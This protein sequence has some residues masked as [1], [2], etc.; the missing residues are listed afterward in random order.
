MKNRNL[1]T[2]WGVGT[3]IGLLLLG[4]IGVYVYATGDNLY[5]GIK[6]LDRVAFEVSRNYVEEVNPKD[7]VYAG[8]KGML[9][10]LDPH[11]QFF[12]QK[13]YKELM[14]GT[15]G[16][17]SGVGMVIGGREGVLTV[18][19]PIE[20]G[21]AY[22]AGIQAGDK[23]IKIEGE[24]TEGIT[25]EEAST[26]LRG[27]KGT[28]VSLSIKRE[29][30]DEPLEFALIRDI[31]T[32]KSV[33]YA[34]IVSNGIGYIRLSRFSENAGEEIR[35]ALNRVGDRAQ[36]GLILDLRNNP[37]GLLSQ[38]VDVSDL[39]L[40]QGK[41][42]V[43]TEGRSSQQN[44]RFYSKFPSLFGDKP[45]II[46]VNR[47][48]A[49]AS[50]I[51]SG[52]VQD[53][54]RGLILG[55]RTF[56]K[57][58]V[59]T[60]IKPGEGT[61]FER[62][63]LKITTAK[64]YIPSGRCIQK[65]E[66]VVGEKDTTEEE[67]REEFK[68]QGGRTVYGGGG[69]IP[70]VISELPTP[71]RLEL[72]LSRKGIFFDFAVDYTSRYMD[73]TRNFE[74]TDQMLSEFKEFLQAK[75]FHYTSKAE[76]QLENLEKSL[77]EIEYNPDTERI[78]EELR[79]KVLAAKEKEFQSSL[80]YIKMGIKREIVSKLWGEEAVYEEFVV[81]SDKQVQRAMEILETPGEYEKL[82]GL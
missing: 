50:E 44:R 16:K 46:L 39:F 33:P 8:I 71:N 42:V 4:W 9:K 13:Q 17:Y 60:V 58:S 41:L 53:W 24:S 67:Q 38:A 72:E 73:L 23:V 30:V 12:E 81:K 37:G 32:I 15:Q 43:Y 56:G 77:K 47:G 57:G 61:P 74:V 69:V 70:D 49:S 80:D 7:L 22:K 1:Y 6:L 59:Q 40:P 11:T 52:A 63:A 3:F 31:I 34:G 35:E 21:P 55:T 2:I 75:D 51:I 19:S 48:S 68:T 27:P 10:I 54:D 14:I 78:I 76:S 20:G 82:L 62:T 26:K 28:R 65:E 18:I 79:S 66:E 45:L 29:G 5:A 25:T 64:W 36:K